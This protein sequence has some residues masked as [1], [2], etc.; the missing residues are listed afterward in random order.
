MSA[1]TI[2]LLL[3]FSVPSAYASAN[4]DLFEA[5]HSSDKD[6]V[7]LALGNGAD[8]NARGPGDQTPLMAAVLGGKTEVVKALLLSGADT[9]LPE[10]DGYTPMHG[11]GFQVCCG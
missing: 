7:L 4:D 5:V 8:I 6:R 9:T 2:F 10:K 3:L 1:Y 11:A